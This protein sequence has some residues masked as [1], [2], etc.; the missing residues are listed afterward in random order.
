MLLGFCQDK[1]VF[2]LQADHNKGE[3]MN[4]DTETILMPL[5]FTLST[6]LVAATLEAEDAATSIDS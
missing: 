5:A 4:Q 6:G 1:I 2:V 3:S